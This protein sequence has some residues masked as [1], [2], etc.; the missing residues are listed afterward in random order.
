MTG[1][2]RLLL[3]ILVIL[4][5]VSLITLLARRHFPE[6]HG[7]NPCYC[8]RIQIATATTPIKNAAPTPYGDHRRGL[9]WHDSGHLLKDRREILRNLF[10]FD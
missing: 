4:T 9:V 6:A 8:R 2:A 10:N 3:L 1:D 5:I 7:G